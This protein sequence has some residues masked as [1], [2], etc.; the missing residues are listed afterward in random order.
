MFARVCSMGVYALEGFAV[1]VEADISG[2]LPQFAIVG[3]PDNAVKEATDR[4]RS[5]L[6]NLN[7]TYPVSRITIN[8]A[9][10]DI[11]KTGPVYD[12]PVLLAILAASGQIKDL[13]DDTAFVGELSLDGSIRGVNGIL[14]MTIA[15][16][17]CGK[18]AIFVP[19]NNALE[20]SAVEGIKIYAVENA[21]QVVLHLL[22]ENVLPEVP[23]LEFN[24]Q[25]VDEILDFADV[26][27]QL[28]AKRALEIAAAGGHNLLM[29]G[30]PGS[31]KS[32]LA[33]RLPGI[34][35]P[36]TRE[37]AMETTKIY[38]V[39]GNMKN[40][41]GLITQRPFRAPH[42]SVSATGL[43][44]GGATPRPGE[45]SL[46][47]NGVLFL[48]E[49]PEFHRDALE[50]LRQPVEDGIVT[51]SRVAGTA[52]FPCQIMLIAAM[53]P[54]PCGYFG[55]PTRACTCNQSSIDRYLQRISGP[56]LDRI[57]LHVEVLPVD[58]EDIASEENGECSADI[59]V[60]V[61]AARAVQLKR[62]AGTNVACNAQIP[63]AMLRR[64][65][66]LS[67]DANK[68]LKLAFER[69]GL[70]A[71]AY[72]R[73]LKVS[74]TIADL[75]GSDIIDTQHVSEAVQYRNMDR[76]YWYTR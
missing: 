68:L 72:D 33:K 34:L 18:K 62:F 3:L 54:C 32:M 76:K 51:V 17:K 75:D 60:R 64:I 4:V 40:G 8:L 37:E 15:A 21:K 10:A 59:A 20:A 39:A 57:D 22:G 53:N 67:K 11:K 46:A 38:S 31:G 29:V 28:E 42:H 74:R 26:R 58:Y 41:V 16:Q 7:Y 48:D 30:S 36:L 50:I 5:A 61:A 14:P 43:S 52:T 47:H 45:I 71:R 13:P 65:C 27:G 55:H 9:P 2:G 49:L 23:A 6:K 70:S 35:P 66:R 1:N 24:T 25:T 69:M 73:V 63:S 56:L 19:S 44:G 12:L